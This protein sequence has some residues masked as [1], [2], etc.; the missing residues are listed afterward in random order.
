[1]AGDSRRV[2][3]RGSLNGASGATTIRSLPRD[4]GLQYFRSIVIR[5]R[6]ISWRISEAMAASSALAPRHLAVA[7][8]LCCAV[9]LGVSGENP[10]SSDPCIRSLTSR[11]G[12]QFVRTSHL[13][14]VADKPPTYPPYSSSAIPRTPSAKLGEV[15]LCQVLQ[16]LPWCLRIAGH[17]SRGVY[18]H[19]VSTIVERQRPVGNRP[20]HDRIACSPNRVG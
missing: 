20:N 15:G 12:R 13:M 3:R 19:N 4:R 5:Q 10:R 11:G 2:L 7:E 14:R 6:R 16:I 18:E 8:R 17:E 1:M 9:D